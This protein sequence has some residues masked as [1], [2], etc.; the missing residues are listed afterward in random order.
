MKG[1]FTRNTFDPGKQYSR[2]LMQQGRVQLD[3]DWNEQSSILLHYMRT[4]ARDLIGPHGAPEQR[5]DS[6]AVLPCSSFQVV[7][8]VQDL[9][10][11]NGTP[12]AAGDDA[13]KQFR[14]TL[15]DNKDAVAVNPGRYYVD[16]LLVESTTPRIVEPA[17]N[18][19]GV[20]VDFLVY[21]DVW[22]RHVTCVEDPH[23]RETA[24]GGPDTTTRT[25]V[26]WQ[27]NTCPADGD[28]CKLT[29]VPVEPGTGLLRAYA[30]PGPAP[31]TPCVIAPASS[32]RGAENQLYRVEI[33]TGGA[34]GAATFK[35]SREN[36]SVVFPVVGGPAGANPVD[37]SAAITVTVA[38]LGRDGDVGLHVGDWVE[39]LDE[40][41][42][43]QNRADPLLKVTNI[44]KDQMKVTLK[45]TTNVA[46][47]KN[48]S[49]ML[50]RRWDQGS[51]A[52]KV[53][54]TD[55]A[56]ATYS[57]WIKLEDGIVVCFVKSAANDPARVYR[58]GDYWLIPAR[59][60]AGDIEWPRKDGVP[61]PRPPA[62]PHHH[63][64]PLAHRNAN[65]LM[66]CRRCFPALAIPCPDTGTTNKAPSAK[67]SGAGKKKADG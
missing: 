25:Q 10:D 57:G 11:A 4:L 45:G 15:A 26:V 36:G 35:W 41:Y 47:D 49:N 6:G 24:L 19:D 44:D 51:D 61:Q 22:E 60:D 46:G 53:T 63:Y 37:G 65:G 66:S 1:D 52:V 39:L 12:L 58:S 31:S 8:R 3:S 40:D 29:H 34:V 67:K 54:E 64:A 23:I 2:V 20:V 17:A 33:H 30:G 59:V 50:L 21:L 14:T 48:Q 32:Y 43:M 28:S 13:F 62:G 7:T 18:T 9:K 55:A 16:G 27:V 38:T 42:V 5:D 56:D